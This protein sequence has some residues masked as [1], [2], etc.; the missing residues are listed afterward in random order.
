MTAL[1][2]GATRSRRPTDA[3]VTSPGSSATRRRLGPAGAGAAARTRRSVA[4]AARSPPRLRSASPRSCPATST[5]LSSPLRRARETALAIADAARSPGLCPARPG[6]GR[7]RRASRASRGTKLAT[8]RAG[9]G[10]PDRRRRARRLARR[11]DGGLACA[12]R[13]ARM[14][15]ASGTRRA[16]RRRQPRPVP[17]G[18]PRGARRRGRRHHGAHPVRAGE[19]HPGPV[20][21]TEGNG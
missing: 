7:L 21:R 8:T 1:V 6:R 18:A 15:T 11:R 14:A 17:R 12:G 20:R 10:R 4:R 13:A 3:P 19:R 5:I 2:V 9:S 16:G